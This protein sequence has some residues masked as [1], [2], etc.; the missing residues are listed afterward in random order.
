MVRTVALVVA[1]LPPIFAQSPA[2][3]SVVSPCQDFY[4]YA[5]GPW[6]AS[7]PIPAA[8]PRWG[9]FEELQ[10]RNREV[11]REIL[12]KSRG[13]I[14]DYYAACMDVA[15][16]NRKGI[17]P[18][19][20]ELERI[21]ALGDKMAI[22]AEVARLHRIG[23]GALF[24]FSSG[25]DFRNSTVNIAQADQ[26]GLG[27][28]DRDYY[29]KTD[30]KSVELRE[31]YLAHVEKMLQ[32]LGEPPARAKNNAQA[33][34]QIETGLAKGSLD[35]T[36]RRE[37]SKIYHKM[38]KAELISLNPDI[39]WP[40][41]FESI[42]AP[43]F[44]SLNVAV[45][46]FFRRLEEL[47]VLN[48]LDRWKAYLTWH[49]VHARAGLL[50]DAL[51]EENFNFYGRIL[52]GAKELRPRWKRC[53]SYTNRQLG[54]ALGKA[55]VERTFGPEG[56]ERTLRMV[57][58]I[59]RAMGQDMQKLTWMTPE[60]KKQALVKLRAIV[61]KI[62]YPDK[63]RDYSSVKIARDDASGNAARAD[64]F[65]FKR[66][67]DKIGK[68]VD[69]GEWQMTPPTVDAY[70]EDSM[71]TINFPAGI[72]QP[73]F[74]DRSA[75][76][77]SNYGAIGSVIGHEMTH[78]FDDEGS[79]FDAQGNLRNWWTPRDRAAF[80]AREQCFVDEYAGFE[81]V[82]GVH[83]NGKLTLGENTADNGGVRLA[84]MALLAT[85]GSK[86]QEQQFFLG[87]AQIWCENEREE[88]ARMRVTVDPHSPAAARVNGVVQN[89]PEFGK[90]FACT[91][92]QPMV[93]PRACRVW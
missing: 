76:D 91:A 40:R 31:Q 14:G 55:F 89:M 21:A 6:K 51:V 52:T 78:G 33:V 12:E 38:T 54:F 83:L 66:Q 74:F 9:S 92:G 90:A 67:M 71:N 39:A 25:P 62:G 24:D 75:G 68:P 84:L 23:V 72:L 35:R 45:P 65:E 27:L 70:Y 11:L 18:L 56:K 64:Q 73:P 77:A 15:T 63:W 50:P 57:R 5:C 59:E 22:T 47:L 7:H 2:V 82:E 16:I 53:V 34:M 3:D 46:G 93:S 17:E 79:Q 26:G 4:Q 80:Q 29:L 58:A 81:A 10:D 60:T 44:D 37:P 88:N 1:L 36:L 43:E 13:Q 28:P 48:N 32:L 87:F 85:A 20:P 41:Y 61:N 19:K 49:L 8:E 30:T 69:R 86:A 42:E